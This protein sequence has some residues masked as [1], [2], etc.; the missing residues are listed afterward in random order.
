MVTPTS[1]MQFSIKVPVPAEPEE[2]YLA[3]YVPSLPALS[4][5]M[6]C[7][8]HYCLNW[9]IRAV[10]FFTSFSVSCFALFLFGFDVFPEAFSG[11][12]VSLRLRFLTEGQVN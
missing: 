1:A 6:H 9:E 10:F 2:M 3:C 4:F 7:V 11:R 5:S 8:C 12:I